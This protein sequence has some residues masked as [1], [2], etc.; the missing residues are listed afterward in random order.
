MSTKG[1]GQSEK[2]DTRLK[3]GDLVE[4]ESLFF[5]FPPSKSGTTIAL[6]QLNR[7]LY[8]REFVF[9]ESELQFRAIVGCQEIKEQQLD[10]Y[11][12]KIHWLDSMC[13][14]MDERLLDKT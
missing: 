1:P 2:R 13:Y 12:A 10:S 3:R 5:I 14:H 8:L 9:I 7:N 11:C 6:A 4:N